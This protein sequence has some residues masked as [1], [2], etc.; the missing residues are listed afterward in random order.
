MHSSL[1]CVISTIEKNN[2]MP[3]DIESVN[4]FCHPETEL[5]VWR[6][7]ELAT[8]V[9]SQFNTPYVIAAAAHRVRL[10]DWQD[11]DT[12]RNP[13]IVEFMKKVNCQVHPQ[14]FEIGRKDP[15]NFVGMVE[16]VAKGKTFKEERLYR[17]SRP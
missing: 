14:L 5:P 8:H 1:D 13:K 17:N 6:S 10:E 3:E 4:V 9:D 7:N 15:R 11:W 12:I 16:V 2:L